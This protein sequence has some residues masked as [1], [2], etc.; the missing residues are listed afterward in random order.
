M[1][2]AYCC[3]SRKCHLYFVVP[4]KINCCTQDL[5]RNEH[6]K[7]C[8][9]SNKYLWYSI[10]KFISWPWNELLFCYATLV[11]VTCTAENEQ[12]NR[13][14]CDNKRARK[15]NCK[16]LI[17]INNNITKYV[18]IFVAVKPALFRNPCVE[19]ENKQKKPFMLSINIVKLHHL[20]STQTVPSARE[21]YI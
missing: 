1:L 20:Q 6:K 3:I 10:F 21:F 13:V 7:L 18:G 4:L 14:T 19:L 2:W 5:T 8:N 15:T 11:L 17:D 9:T 12:T 16:K